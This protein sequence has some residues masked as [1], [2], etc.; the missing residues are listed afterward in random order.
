[1][2]SISNRKVEKCSAFDDHRCGWPA[3]VASIR[4]LSKTLIHNLGVGDE[5]KVSCHDIEATPG[6]ALQQPPDLFW[7]PEGFPEWELAIESEQCVLEDPW[8]LLLQP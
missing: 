2:F 5:A 3:G 6:D 7:Y 8:V 1:M 4:R